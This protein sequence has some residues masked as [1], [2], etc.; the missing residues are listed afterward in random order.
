MENQQTLFENKEVAS[1]PSSDILLGRLVMPSELRLLYHAQPLS[2]FYHDP[3]FVAGDGKEVW[4]G[5]TV[6]F[7]TDG[8]I[9][10]RSGTVCNYNG[11]KIACFNTSLNKWEYYGIDA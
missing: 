4:K 1:T 10:P 3:L 5:D 9:S 11:L 2:R 8:E 7:D 6:E